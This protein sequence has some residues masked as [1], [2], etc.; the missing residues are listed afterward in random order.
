MFFLCN[1]GVVMKK[2]W[3]LALAAVLF[4]TQ[5]TSADVVVSEFLNNA[6]STD[7]GREWIEF[8]NTTGS[9][10]DLTGWTITDEGSNTYTFGT[11][12]IGANGFLVVVNSNGVGSSIDNDAAAKA[13]FE[14]E[15]LGG[16]SD[17]RV[18]GGNFG[19]LGNS[20]DEIILTDDSAAVQF[21]LAYMNDEDEDST[22]LLPQDF[23]TIAYGTEASPGIDRAGDDNGIVGFL[24][25]QDSGDFSSI[26]EGDFTA[27]QDTN[28]L[29]SIGVDITKYDGV[30]SASEGDPLGFSQ[31]AV[32]EP[33][34]S[35]VLAI[36]GVGALCRRK[37]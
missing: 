16:V 15:W 7:D 30:D 6:D 5:V 32:P 27:I 9:A 28:F 19:A 2:I 25:F 37:R 23:G 35:A 4:S 17:A 1:F 31:A 11:V 26:F 8:Y 3:C 34:S 10:I 33:T 20:A 22:A 12:T 13:I 18:I 24:G 36:L 14:A 29:T 21:S